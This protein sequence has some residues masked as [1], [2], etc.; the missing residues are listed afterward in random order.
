MCLTKFP[1][2]APFDSDLDIHSD[3]VF[4]VYTRAENTKWCSKWIYKFTVLCFVYNT[5]GINRRPTTDGE[6]C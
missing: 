6:L 5:L 2:S 1:L 4:D 3:I